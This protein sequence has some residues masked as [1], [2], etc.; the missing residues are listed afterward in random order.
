MQFG[1]GLILGG[2]IGMITTALM[3]VASRADD[4]MARLEKE[5]ERDE[6]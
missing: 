5:W 2:V 6:W 4:S 1:L 3:V